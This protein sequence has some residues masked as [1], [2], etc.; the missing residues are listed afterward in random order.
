MGLMRKVEKVANEAFAASGRIVG[1]IFDTKITK[2]NFIKS[3][4][5][6]SSVPILM[7]IILLIIP[8]SPSVVP[9]IT[10]NYNENDKDASV[11]QITITDQEPFAVNLTCGLSGWWQMDVLAVLP[12]KENEKAIWNK[13]S[14]ETSE[15]IEIAAVSANINHSAID[16]MQ[17]FIGEVCNER[18]VDSLLLTFYR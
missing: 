11:A 3:I 12:S 15:S 13:Y 2:N 9:V 8:N 16:E 10:D 4:L 7:G 18:D 14:S 5:F 6:I 17:T 1:K